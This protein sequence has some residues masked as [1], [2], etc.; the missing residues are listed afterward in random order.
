MSYLPIDSFALIFSF[1]ASVLIAPVSLPSTDYDLQYLLV[2]FGLLLSLGLI[3]ITFS[4]IQ[5][6]RNKERLTPDEKLMYQWDVK[7]DNDLKADAPTK[8]DESP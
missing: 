8:K 4:S 3:F 7:M 5:E 2:P 6:V 1:F